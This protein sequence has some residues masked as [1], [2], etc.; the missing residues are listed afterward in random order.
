M[1]N[2]QETDLFWGGDESLTLWMSFIYSAR[3]DTINYIWKF[4]NIKILKILK[5]IRM[6]NIS[7]YY[8]FYCIDQINAE[9]DL[10]QINFLNKS[11]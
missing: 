7:Q 4:E 11:N 1:R 3:K 6:N 2:V 10:F 5:Q 9:T 8:C